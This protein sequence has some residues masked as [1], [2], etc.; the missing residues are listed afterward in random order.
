[1]HPKVGCYFGAVLSTWRNTRSFFLFFTILMILMVLSAVTATARRSP[2]RIGIS[3]FACAHW[4]ILRTRAHA[5]LRT[6]KAH[7][8]TAR[9]V[10]RNVYTKLYSTKISFKTTYETLT[11]FEQRVSYLYGITKPN[12]IVQ[13]LH[14]N[15]FGGGPLKKHLSHAS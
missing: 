11:D 3:R 9:A 4:C 6:M 10:I 13:V 8:V 15:F 2:T 1:M 14:R 12:T 7:E 5:L